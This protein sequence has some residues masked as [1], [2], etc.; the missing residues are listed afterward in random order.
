MDRPSRKTRVVDYRDLDDDEDFARVKPRDGKRP[1]DATTE[2]E[3]KK[4]PSHCGQDSQLSAEHKT[5]KPLDQRLSERDLEAAVTL[6][7]LHNTDDDDDKADLSPTM[8]T[9][10]H[11]T[12]GLSPTVPTDQYPATALSPT[13]GQS[14]TLK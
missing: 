9:D 8:H 11:A 3:R 4:P 6:S 1:R 7:L 13:T 10:Q 12:M 5:R 2:M 14:P